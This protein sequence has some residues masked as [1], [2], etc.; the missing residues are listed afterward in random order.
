MAYVMWRWGPTM[1]AEMTRQGLPWPSFSDDEM[2]DL[3][4]FFDQPR[5][6]TK[7]D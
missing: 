7:E 4:A 1:T 6:S 2:T 3:I 5:D